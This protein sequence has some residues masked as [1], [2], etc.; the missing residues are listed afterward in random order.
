VLRSPSTNETVTV[1]LDFEE[2]DRFVSV[3]SP[4]AGPLFDRVTGRVVYA[5]SQH[6]DDLVI[7]RHAHPPT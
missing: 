2:D 5:L 4:D 7:E 1:K 6:S 3:Y